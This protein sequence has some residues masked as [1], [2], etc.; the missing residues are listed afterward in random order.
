MKNGEGSVEIRV[1]E[2]RVKLL[3]LR[4]SE[5]TF[6]NNRA[7]GERTEIGARLAFRLDAFAQKEKLA[8]EI[9]GGI[10]AFEKALAD[11]GRRGRGERTQMSWM[12]GHISPAEAS[13]ARFLRERFDGTARVWFAILRKENHAKSE[14]LRESAT[15]GELLQTEKSPRNREQESS[16]VATQAVGIHAAAMREA[17]E[18]DQGAFDNIAR[19]RAAQSSDEADSAGVMIECRVERRIAHLMYLLQ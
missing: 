4:G 16:A 11:G 17:A 2:I 19:G 14:I 18:R 3:K 15:R 6:V 12:Y 8:L 9:Q 7:G 10:G 13:Q 1:R 5:Q